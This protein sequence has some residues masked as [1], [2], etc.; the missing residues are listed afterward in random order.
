MGAVTLTVLALCRSTHALQFDIDTVDATYL[1]DT[2]LMTNQTADTVLV[3]SFSLRVVVLNTF[4]FGCGGAMMVRH[5]FNGPILSNIS[6]AGGGDSVGDSVVLWSV[7]NPSSIPPDY[8][9][10]VQMPYLN[11]PGCPAKRQETAGT[12]TMAVVVTFYSESGDDSVLFVNTQADKACPI[13]GVRSRQRPPREGD[14]R[15]SGSNRPTFAIR[16]ERRVSMATAAGVVVVG[17][18]TGARA[19]VALGGV[20]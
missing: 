12:D 16:G 2:L 1:R 15:A 11:A 3:D 5:F 9:V 8:Q 14:P 18:K 7:T 19:R 4:R 17:D 20:R 6:L 13:S 10:W